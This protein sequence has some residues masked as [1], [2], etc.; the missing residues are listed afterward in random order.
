MLVVKI[1]A[2][3]GDHGDTRCKVKTLGGNPEVGNSDVCLV[4][5]NNNNV[6]CCFPSDVGD[7]QQQ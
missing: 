6:F 7:Q 2:G 5:Y 4:G 1:I 3:G